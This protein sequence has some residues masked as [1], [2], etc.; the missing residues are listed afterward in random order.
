M[1]DSHDRPDM[2]HCEYETNRA[3]CGIRS[4]I[5]LDNHALPIGSPR[6]HRLAGSHLG[7]QL[8]SDLGMRLDAS[9]DEQIACS[10]FENGVARW[11]HAEPREAAFALA[12]GKFLDLQPVLLSA[13]ADPA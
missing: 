9:L 3:A 2:C 11:R 4:A 8:H 1:P 12:G 13:C 6:A 7:A 5:G 10:S